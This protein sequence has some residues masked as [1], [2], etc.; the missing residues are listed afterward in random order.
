MPDENIDGHSVKQNECDLLSADNIAPQTAVRT[1]WVHHQLAVAVQRWFCVNWLFT[2]CRRDHKNF[3]SREMGESHR[4]CWDQA[5]TGTL[6]ILMLY[7]HWKFSK[8]D[9][10]VDDQMNQ[11]DKVLLQLLVYHVSPMF[12]LLTLP[13]LSLIICLLL[14]S[15]RFHAIRGSRGRECWEKSGAWCRNQSNDSDPVWE[16]YWVWQYLSPDN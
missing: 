9:L 3:H 11:G 12:H 15:R 10:G 1:A 14:N 7:S 13:S 2:F 5:H 6:G 16:I 4:K 8:L